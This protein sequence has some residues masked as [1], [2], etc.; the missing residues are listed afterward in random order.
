MTEAIKKK[1]RR[2]DVTLLFLL[3]LGFFISACENDKKE[4]ERVS[5][6]KQEST[7]EIKGLETLYSDSGLVKVRVTAPLLRKKGMPDAVTEL[8]QGLLIEFF[9]ENKKVV[10]KLSAKYAIHYEQEYRWEA[11]N[12]VVVVNEKGEQLNTPKLIWDER[13]EK[14]SSD[15]SVSIK[16]ASEI[17]YGYGFEANQDF[18]QYRIFKVKGRITINE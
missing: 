18:S 3:A 12:D 7:E 11:R 14:I 16:T 17:I 1:L 15:D 5:G 9:N 13:K 6:S 2:Q 10:S 4:I 8:P